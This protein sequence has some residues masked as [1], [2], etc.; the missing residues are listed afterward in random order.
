MKP[1]DTYY[2]ELT[3]RNAT[4]SAATDAD[5]LPTIVV[6]RNGAD[7]P[8]VVATVT[9]VD[10]GRYEFQFV[11]PTSYAYGDTLVVTAEATVAGVADKGALDRFVLSAE[12]AV[13]IIS[14]AALG[15]P[16][17]ASSTVRTYS[18][19]ID[20]L[21][22]IVNAAANEASNERRIRRAIQTAYRMFSDA[23]DWNYLTKTFRVDLV[24]SQTVGTISFS[25]ASNQVTL[26]GSTWPSW[27]ADGTLRVGNIDAYVSTRNSDTVLTLDP[28]LTF[29]ADLPAGTTYTFY[30]AAYPLPDDFRKIFDPV[31][32]KRLWMANYISPETY[33][34]LKRFSLTQGPPTAYTIMG[35]RLRTGG[36]SL[37]VFPA[38]TLDESY[39]MVYLRVARP[40]IKS[41]KAVAESKGTLSGTA[42]QTTVTGVGTTWDASMVGS[43]LR[44]SP[45]TTL[46]DGIDGLN[47]FSEQIYITSASATSL[48]LAAPLANSY[49]GVAFAVSDPV[50]M[51][52]KMFPALL[53]CCEWQLFILLERGNIAEAQQRYYQGARLAFEADNV[54]GSTEYAEQGNH[55]PPRGMA[56]MPVVYP[57]GTSYP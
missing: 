34:M 46:P 4:T 36:H 31:S 50:D 19:L 9:H 10:T 16:S 26:S 1:G 53:R 13:S 5:A 33:N 25:R 6:S 20:H 14:A 48:T 54:T 29:I 30:Q 12:G 2:G 47:P 51:P 38:P 32:E 40:M 28:D 49:A 45:N 42:G 21:S 22:D 3:T 56:Y 7:D 35:D 37:F 43:L 57:D 52:A 39:D 8:A 15:G 41:G 23:R 55:G 17:A 44:I 18:D 11:I 27:A 24:A